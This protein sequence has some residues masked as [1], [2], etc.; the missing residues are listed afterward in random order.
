MPLTGTFRVVWINDPASRCATF[1]Q[2]KNLMLLFK[3]EIRIRIISQKAIYLKAY[4][5]ASIAHLIEFYSY[6]HFPQLN[7]E[8][9]VVY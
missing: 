8:R 1:F 6:S 7:A 5:R 2:M 9:T 3:Y 4:I